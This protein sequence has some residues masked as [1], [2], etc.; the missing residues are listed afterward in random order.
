M[1]KKFDAAFITET[2]ERVVDRVGDPTPLVYERLFKA[3]PEMEAMFAM[4]TTGAVRGH[5][6]SEALDGIIDFIGE[7]H[8]ADNLIRSEIV[9]HEGMGVPPEVFSTFYGVVAATFKDILGADWTDDME[10]AWTSV[11]DEL[12]A[13]VKE[14]V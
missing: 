8:Y 1:T 4:D 5:M 2:L 14:R 9:N 11:L 10:K 13:T 6:L 7:R 12:S 3:Q